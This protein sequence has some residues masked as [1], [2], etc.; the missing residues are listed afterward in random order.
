MKIAGGCLIVLA[1]A[2]ALMIVNELAVVALRQKVSLGEFVNEF[3]GYWWP[4]GI[5]LV[6]G[7]LFW[8]YKPR[9][10]IY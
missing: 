3:L 2:V 1:I 5:A 8:R 7:V 4:Y 6:V 10:K 9:N